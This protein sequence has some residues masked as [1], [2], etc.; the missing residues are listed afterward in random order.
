MD[1][2]WGNGQAEI[3]LIEDN[4]DDVLLTREA[5]GRCPGP[6]RLAVFQD[7]A[8]ALRYLRRQGPYTGAARP[9]LVLLDLNLPGKPGREVLTEIKNDGELGHIPVIILSTTMIDR[10]ILASYR[11]HAN[12]CVRKPMDVDEFFEAIRKIHDFWLNVVVLPAESAD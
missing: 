2:A 6:P 7:G 8:E 1:N 3:L 9:R 12:G 10:E 11:L 5:L 4:P